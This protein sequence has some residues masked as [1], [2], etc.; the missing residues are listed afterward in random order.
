MIEALASGVPVAA[1]PATG[2]IDTITE[3]EL[4]ALDDDLAEAIHRAL[5]IGN[6]AACAAEGRTYTWESF[7]LRSS[8]A[9]WFLPDLK[10]PNDRSRRKSSYHDMSRIR[11]ATDRFS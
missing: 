6:P 8:K 5:A 11:F 4:G 9:I 7:A 2:P 3:T 10:P 1:Y